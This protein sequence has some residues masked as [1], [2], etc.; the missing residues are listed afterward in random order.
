MIDLWSI[1]NKLQSSVVSYV[2]YGQT[3]EIAKSENWVT[4]FCINTDY[5]A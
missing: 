3:I 2:R 4:G 1:L 5:L